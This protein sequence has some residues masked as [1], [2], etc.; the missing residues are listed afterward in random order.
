MRTGKGALGQ[1][2]S[3][4]RGAREIDKGIGEDIG[5]V[6]LN[7]GL[8]TDIFDALQCDGCGNHR[9]ALRQC[10]YELDFQAGS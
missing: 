3:S 1:V 9:L 8:T 10:L 7:D 5:V 2:C 6:G 4:S